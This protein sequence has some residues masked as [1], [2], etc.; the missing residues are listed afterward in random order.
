LTSILNN[1]KPNVGLITEESSNSGAYYISLIKYISSNEK[2]DKLWDYCLNLINERQCDINEK[3]LNIAMYYKRRGIFE[4]KK[5]H[6]EEW[7]KNGDKVKISSARGV[8]DSYALVTD[9]VQPFKIDG[10]MV[11]MVG[12]IWHFGQ[13]CES[14]GDSCNTLTPS[15]GDPNSSIPEYKAFLVNI[16]KA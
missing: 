5:K 2:T 15:V 14:T 11:E 4:F 6:A 9:R 1:L 16:E 10:K 7:I 3:K 12:M 8:I 13:G